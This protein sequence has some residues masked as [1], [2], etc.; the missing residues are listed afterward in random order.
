MSKYRDKDP[1]P[2]S[3]RRKRMKQVSR[4]L[5][6]FNSIHQSRTCLSSIPEIIL[7][8]V[9]DIIPSGA[10]GFQRSKECRQL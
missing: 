4:L 2:S 7:P 10:V 6:R 8:Q 3:I 9:P 5:M 1:L